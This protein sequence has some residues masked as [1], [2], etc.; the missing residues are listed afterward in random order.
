MRIL[1]IS[2]FVLFIQCNLKPQNIF[3]GAIIYNI[4]NY[5]EGKLDTVPYGNQVTVYIKNGHLK[6][7]YNSTH[8]N[9][10]REEI[11]DPVSGKI[12][13]KI[14]S[15]DTIYWANQ[16]KNPYMNL[17]EME[18]KKTEEKIFNQQCRILKVKSIF[19]KNDLIFEY[20]SKYY[21]SDTLRVNPS[22]FEN[23]KLGY[24]SK[25]I[26]QMK[27]YYLKSIEESPTTK[28][29]FE[30]NNIQP[31]TLDFGI[32]AIDKNLPTKEYIY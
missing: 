23:W 4:T 28:T 22:D 29:V 16:K 31:A 18:I 7:V 30:I 10:I 25:S 17:K 5:T 6:R 26:D 8:E 19:T 11:F 14:G 12:Y 2:S 32:F 9:A 21:F 1:I 3:E 13:M 24:F 20:N 15:S 27:A